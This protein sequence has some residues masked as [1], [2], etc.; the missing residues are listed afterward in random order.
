MVSSRLCLK[1]PNAGESLVVVP[2]T[3]ECVPEV[4][5]WENK[6]SFFL[7]LGMRKLKIRSR[8]LKTTKEI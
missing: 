7:I 4:D 2:L 8:G 3:S 5:L 1:T 6:A